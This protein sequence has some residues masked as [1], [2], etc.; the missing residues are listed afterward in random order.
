MHYIKQQEEDDKEDEEKTATA[1]TGE[2]KDCVGINDIK[3]M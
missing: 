1:A 2:G 3:L